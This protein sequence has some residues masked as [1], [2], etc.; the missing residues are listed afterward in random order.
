MKVG[1]G[2]G[3]TVGS[4]VGVGV[5]SGVGDGDGVGVGVGDGSGVGDSLVSVGEGDSLEGDGLGVTIGVMKSATGS[6][7]SAACM[8]AVQMATV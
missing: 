8:K 1:S 3:D 4:G 2:V 7:A 6:A 5:G